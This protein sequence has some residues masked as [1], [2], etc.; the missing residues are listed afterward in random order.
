MTVVSQPLAR[1][2]EGPANS[3]S[4][5]DAL[6][7]LADGDR[8]AFDAVHAE[9]RPLIE[10][11]VRRATTPADFGSDGDDIVQRT[12]IR[13]FETCSRYDRQR[14]AG[15]WICTLAAFEV[16]SALRDRARRGARFSSPDEA[17][18]DPGI[19][20]EDQ[21]AARELVQAAEAAL[22]ELSDL[23]KETLLASLAGADA[24]QGATF[25]KRL[26]RASRRFFGALRG[27]GHGKP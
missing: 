23:D 13:L 9:A 4:L 14:P 25:R 11:F 16:R 24:P 7:R 19:G 18:V 26:E 12:L 22:G 1:R 5:S 21:A 15:P 2:P 17:L 20:P 27:H 8:A 10:R 6:A 3:R